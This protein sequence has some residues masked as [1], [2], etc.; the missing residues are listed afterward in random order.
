MGADG[1]KDLDAVK[2]QFPEDRWVWVWNDEYQEWVFWDTK[3]PGVGFAYRNANDKGTEYQEY[4]WVRVYSIGEGPFIAEDRNNIPEQ[5]RH[6]WPTRDE[7]FDEEPTE[8]ELADAIDQNPIGWD[9]ED[10]PF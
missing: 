6:M 7:V 3:Y 2:Q 5:V 10:P 9:E 1:Y 8:Q 4:W